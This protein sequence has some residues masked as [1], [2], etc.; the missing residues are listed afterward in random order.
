MCVLGEV[1]VL[2]IVM[3]R[4]LAM[5]LKTKKLDFYKVISDG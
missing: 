5:R 1:L 2:F 4:A 3:V